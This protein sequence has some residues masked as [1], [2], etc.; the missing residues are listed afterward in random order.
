MAAM[1]QA[2]HFQ[3][4]GPRGLVICGERGD[5]ETESLLEVAR[6][7]FHPSLVTAFVSE[8]LLETAASV[9]PLTRGR[10]SIEGRPT[11]YVC[12]NQTCRLPVEKVDDL[13]AQLRA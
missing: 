9:L 1:M 10:G 8:E 13:K 2:L 3:L 7:E 4:S 5:P 6:R 12:I 11:A